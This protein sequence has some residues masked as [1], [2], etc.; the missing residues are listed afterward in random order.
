MFNLKHYKSTLSQERVKW[1]NEYLLNYLEKD[2][3]L[4]EFGCGAGKQLFKI[5]ELGLKIIGIEISKE[6]IKRFNKNK[7][8]I[9][10]NAKIIKGSYF[11]VPINENSIDYVLFAKNIIECSYKEFEI[12]C[13]EAKKILVENG[14]FIITMSED[15]E[16]HERNIKNYDILEGKY[17]GR[18]DT[19]TKKDV[20]YHTFYWTIGFANYILSKEFDFVEKVMEIDEKGTTLL[21]YKKKNYFA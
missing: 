12:I 5:E 9:K 7:I 13:K 19:P 3:T 14:I 8:V 17:T 16:K 18:I 21:I 1:I 2:K 4:I 11:N 20:N 6:M 15:L 10:S